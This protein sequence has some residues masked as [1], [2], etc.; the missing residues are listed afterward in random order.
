M[1][2]AVPAHQVNLPR[3]YRF[4]DNGA[5]I[6]HLAEVPERQEYVDTSTDDADADYRQEEDSDGEYLPDEEFSSD[7]AGKLCN[8]KLNFIV[9]NVRDLV[10]KLLV[11]AP[12]THFKTV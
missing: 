1:Y 11:I 7:E 6:L 4:D 2:P 3:H 8:S 10:N 5:M 12:L 9:C